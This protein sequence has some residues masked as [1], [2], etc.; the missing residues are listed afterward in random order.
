[1]TPHEHSPTLAP[2]R[3]L[4]PP[5]TLAPPRTLVPPPGLLARARA[6]AAT[7]WALLSAQAAVLGVDFVWPLAPVVSLVTSIF[8]SLLVLPWGWLVLHGGRRSSAPGSGP[9]VWVFR[10]ILL[11]LVATFLGARWWLR[12]GQS[13][14]DLAAL[15]GTWRS[16]AVALSLLLPLGLLAR[17][18]RFS[19]LV[20][21][22]ADH[23][24]RLMALSFAVAGV[25]GGLLLS[26]PPAMQRVHELSLVDNLFMAFSAVCVTGLSVNTLSMTYTLFGQVVLCLLIQIGGLG[27]MVLSAAIAL[28]TGQRMRIK[29]SAMLA[30]I[31]DS[32]SLAN[33]RRVVRAIVISTFAIEAAGA[34]LLYARFVQHPDLLAKSNWLVGDVAHPGWLAVFHAV[35]AFCNAGFSNLHPGLVPFIG[36]PLVM[37][38]VI[39]LIVLGGI[40]FP[41]IHELSARA[42]RSARRRRLERLSLHTR[43]S[44]RATAALLGGVAAAYLILE[45][46]TSFA[47][48]HW[49]ERIA[50]ALFQSASCRTAGFNVVDVGAMRPASLMLTCVAMFIGACSG[51]C[52]GGIKTTTVAA[53]FA[54]LRSELQGR[55]A[56]LLD[57]GVSTATIR[58]AVGVAF[59]SIGLVSLVLFVLLLIDP[60]APLALAFEVFSAFS[61]TGLSMGITPELSTA[62][63]I[64]V[65]LTMYM[66]RIGPLTLALALSRRAPAVPVQVPEERVLIG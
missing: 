25:M 28:L 24:A 51:S 63:K 32:E 55:P 57:R 14:V 61:T 20:T 2:P 47:S 39:A 7:D 5:H 27:I 35:S 18:L 46:T 3:T 54:G 44:L 23:P 11:A 36:D 8:L 30:E 6:A 15:A 52:A 29:S 22:V 33:L 4:A 60:H 64:L 9:K 56:Y 53:L 26:L 31:I 58:K 17:E 1:M 34:L 62:A 45:W 16:Y 42:L 40:G 59:M 37:G 48:L 19:K 66:G 21:L 10:M 41:V 65:L 49:G 43:V 38:T 12:L 50:A 13:S